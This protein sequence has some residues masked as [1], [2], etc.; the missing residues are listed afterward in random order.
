MA[1]RK[2]TVTIDESLLDAID[3]LGPDNLSALVNEALGARIDQ[4]ARRQALRAILDGWDNT[5]GPVP[6]R[7]A[8]AAAAAFD[9]LDGVSSA[10]VA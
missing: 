9:E 10:D 5:H 6:A 2:I 7:F 8:T 1:K 4:L 3:R